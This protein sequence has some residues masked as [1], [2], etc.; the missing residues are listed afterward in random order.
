MFCRLGVSI[1]IRSANNRNRPRFQTHLE[2]DRE[3]KAERERKR[4][5]GREE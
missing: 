5:R 4:E 3:R 2:G 1:I